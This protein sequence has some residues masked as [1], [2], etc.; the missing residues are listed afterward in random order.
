MTNCIELRGRPSGSASMSLNAELSNGRLDGGVY[1]F[2]IGGNSGWTFST[3]GYSCLTVANDLLEIA[4]QLAEWQKID[5]P[6]LSLDIP[7]PI[8]AASIDGVQMSMAFDSGF[9]DLFSAAGELAHNPHYREFH[10]D[11]GGDRSIDIEL[12]QDSALEMS[13]VYLDSIGFAS[14]W[15]LMD[16]LYSIFGSPSGTS[17][18]RASESPSLWERA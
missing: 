9:D 4:R 16:A 11:L 2:D 14:R 13:R 7:A 8:N 17:R 10:Y 15:K 1:S 6:G 5:A 3:S 18:R 12:G